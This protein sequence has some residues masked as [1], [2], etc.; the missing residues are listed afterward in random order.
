MIKKYP[1]FAQRLIES[2][3]NN[4]HISSRAPSQI[5]IKTLAKLL[6]VSEQICR[7]YVRGDALPDYDKIIKISQQLSVSPGWLLFGEPTQNKEE[8]IDDELLHFL[9]MKSFLLYQNEPDANDYANFVLKLLSEIRDIT[10]SKDNLQKIIELA[11]GSIC[12]K[13]KQK[14]QAG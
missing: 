12:Y 4:G 10:T 9:L 7:R 13:E 5:C 1:D 3:L 2:M 6:G 14:K 8:K 11:V